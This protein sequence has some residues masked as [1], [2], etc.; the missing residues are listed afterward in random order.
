VPLDWY[1]RYGLRSDQARLP[2]DASQREALAHQSGADGSPLFDAVWAV[3][4]A[5]Y[6]RALPALEALRQI[7]TQQYSRW[8]V[9]GL[10]ALRGRTTDE[11]PPAALRIT[12]P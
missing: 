11:Q 4:R 5:P 3:E 6:L 7:W 2:K 10:E 1:T 8:T 12:S 9:P